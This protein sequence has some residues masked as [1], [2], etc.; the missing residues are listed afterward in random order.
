MSLIRLC[1]TKLS[2]QMLDSAKIGP[3]RIGAVRRYQLQLSV[4]F[5]LEWMELSLY[6]PYNG[7]ES[8]SM[9]QHIFQLSVLQPEDG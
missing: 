2:L 1:A 3:V 7:T 5:R 8:E 9:F 6:A 4:L